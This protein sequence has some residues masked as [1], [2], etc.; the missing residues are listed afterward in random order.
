MEDMYPVEGEYWSNGALRPAQWNL[1]M[2]W[3]DIFS[4]VGSF[5]FQQCSYDNLKLKFEKAMKE[6]VVN[7][8]FSTTRYIISRESMQTIKIQLLSLGLID[9]YP[10]EAIT[11]SEIFILTDYGRKYLLEKNSIKK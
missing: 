1:K 3:D 4:I 9:L 7:G 5:L 10:S 6:I 8:R 2:S 11:G